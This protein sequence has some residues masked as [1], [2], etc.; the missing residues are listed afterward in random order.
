MCFLPHCFW[1]PDDYGSCL[2]RHVVTWYHFRNSP[3]SQIML[4]V[5]TEFDANK[6]IVILLQLFPMIQKNLFCAQNLR[7]RLLLLLF[8][9]KTI[10]SQVAYLRSGE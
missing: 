9:E 7:H 10:Q 6:A 2:G 3:A 4:Y 1:E 5:L 8:H